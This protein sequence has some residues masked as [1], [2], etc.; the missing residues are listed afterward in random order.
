MNEPLNEYKDYPKWID[1]MSKERQYE[2]YIYAKNEVARL[3]ENNH[4]VDALLAAILEYE[5]KHDIE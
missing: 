2:W 3:K 4:N 1:S 5:S